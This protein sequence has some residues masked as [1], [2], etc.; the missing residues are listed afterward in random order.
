V[1][2]AAVPLKDRILLAARA[3]PSPTRRQGRRAAL[4]ALAVSVALGLAFFELAGGFAHSRDR[5]PGLT[6]RLAGGWSLASSALT[7][8]ARRETAL[9]VRSADVLVAAAIAAPLVLAAWM[10]RFHG[11]Y[12]DPPIAGSWPCGLATLALG[13]TPFASMAWLRRG[14][15]PRHPGVLGATLA[16]MSGAWA[17]L[18]VL[19]WCPVTEVG[20][21]VAGHAAPMALLSVIGCIAGPSVLGVR[22]QKAPALAALRQTSP[23]SL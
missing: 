4:T 7:W 10:S 21:A 11:G 15:E 20:H 1:S 23:P 5:P 19:V 14:C 8:L 22:R 18:P 6:F 17:A 13:L 3:A 2:D 12:L 9:L 16:T